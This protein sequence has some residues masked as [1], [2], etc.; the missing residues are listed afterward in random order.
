M[1][2]FKKQKKN[3][4]W[5]LTQTDS[6]LWKNEVKRLIIIL[7]KRHR[8]IVMYLCRSAVTGGHHW[9]WPPELVWDSVS[10]PE[11]V[12]AWLHIGGHRTSDTTPATFKYIS[13]FK[14]H[15][16]QCFI[17]LTIWNGLKVGYFQG[18]I[19]IGNNDFTRSM[20]S[21]KLFSCM[22]CVFV[23]KSARSSVSLIQVTPV[24]GDILD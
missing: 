16:N 11:P 10:E 19:Y 3:S 17:I 24:V 8:C 15:Q 20:S 4:I 2:V 9:H 18:I 13:G 5:V 6:W 7:C 21:K 14:V 1:G 12:L 23:L 22:A